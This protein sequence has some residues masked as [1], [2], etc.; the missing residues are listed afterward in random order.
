[1]KENT[2]SNSAHLQKEASL[3][4]SAVHGH[5]LPGLDDSLICERQFVGAQAPLNAYHGTT[6]RKLDSILA[7]GLLPGGLDSTRNCVMMS[8]FHYNDPEC[9]G[10]MRFASEVEIEIDL[11]R[12]CSEHNIVCTQS[13]SG[14]LNVRERIPA[15]YFKIITATKTGAWVWQPEELPEGQHWSTRVVQ[16]SEQLYISNGGPQGPAASTSGQ[17]SAASSSWQN[18]STTVQPKAAPKPAM[19]EGKAPPMSIAQTQG[20]SKSNAKTSNR[21]RSQKGTSASTY[22]AKYHSRK[23]HKYHA[24]KE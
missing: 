6:L 20:R 18:P 22:N 4:M 9:R 16:G 7:N 12:Y 17:G 19:P 1:M 13:I 21:H 15:A 10:G 8:P 14:A 5:S 24:S 11:Q 23:R 2:G 3:N